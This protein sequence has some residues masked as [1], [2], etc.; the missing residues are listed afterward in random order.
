MWSKLKFMVTERKGSKLVTGLTSSGLTS[1]VNSAS[2]QRRVGREVPAGAAHRGP[3]TCVFEKNGQDGSIVSHVSSS[4]TS[5]RTTSGH[6]TRGQTVFTRL[7]NIRK[8]NTTKNIFTRM[9]R[10]FIY[11]YS[12]MKQ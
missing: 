4:E 10:L 11:C 12:L 7:S 8:T 9:E 1:P 2:D 6:S 5:A 3:G